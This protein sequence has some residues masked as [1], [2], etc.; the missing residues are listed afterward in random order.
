ML[1]DVQAGGA[2]WRAQGVTAHQVLD[3]VRLIE[4]GSPSLGRFAR[5]FIEQAV[6]DGILAG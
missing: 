4:D 6:A 3:K 2:A 5:R 1:L